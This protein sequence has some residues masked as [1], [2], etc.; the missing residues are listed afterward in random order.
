MVRA[1]SVNDVQL[2]GNGAAALFLAGPDTLLKVALDHA[3]FAQHAFG[4]GRR[5]SRPLAV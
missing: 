5:A 1:W 4:L 2:R 3:L